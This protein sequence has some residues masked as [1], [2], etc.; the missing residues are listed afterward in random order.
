[1]AALRYNNVCWRSIIDS[2]AS[3]PMGVPVSWQRPR[4]RVRGVLLAWVAAS[5]MLVLSFA[6]PAHA[7]VIKSW[8]GIQP[9]GT[10]GTNIPIIISGGASTDGF[11]TDASTVKLFIDGALYPRNRYYASSRS[12]AGLYLLCAPSPALTDGTHTF[13]V[14]IS[15]TAGKLS[16]YQWSARVAQAPAASWVS[17]AAG[18]IY[19]GGRP[20]ITM[21]LSDNTPG[22]HLAVAGQVRTGSATGAVVSTFSG[23]GL[24]G[25]V[26]SFALPGEIAPGTYYLTAT[27]TDGSG[28]IRALTGRL[29]RS[30]KTVLLPAMTRSPQSCLVAGCHVTTGHPATGRTCLQCH[31]PGYHEDYECNEC[32]APHTGPVTVKGIF[33]PCTVCHN[34]SYPGVPSHTAASVTPAHASSC[35]GCHTE[36]LLDR[37][38]VTPE[39][40]AYPYQCDLCH[41]STD[42]DV[43][44]AIAAGDASCSAC[45]DREESH[46][47]LTAIHQSTV[48]SGPVRVLTSPTTNHSAPKDG[49]YAC[50][51][52]HVST[53]LLQAHGT[54]W[55]DCSICH[56]SGGPRSTFDSWNK[57][58]QQGDCHVT[59]HDNGVTQANHASVMTSGGLCGYCHSGEGENYF[60]EAQDCAVVCHQARVPVV[61]DAVAP[62]T[63]VSN[64]AAYFADPAQVQLS[65]TDA[66]SGVTGIYY[67]ADGGGWVY[68]AGSTTTVSVLA[69]GSGLLEFKSVDWLGNTEEIKSYTVTFD[70]TP[71]VTTVSESY[72]GI[73]YRL[74]FSD[75]GSGVA[76]TYFSVDGESFRP[77]GYF[78][79]IDGIRTDGG[80]G[81][82]TVRYYSVDV[83]GNTEDP[84]TVT[85]VIPDNTAPTSTLGRTDGDSAYIESVDAYAD[86]PC[87]IKE[88]RYRLDGGDWVVATF[89]RERPYFATP[90]RADLVVPA[91]GS[92]QLEYFAVDWVDNA[93]TPQTTTLI[94]DGVAPVLAVTVADSYTGNA[95]IPASATDVGSGVASISYRLDSYPVVNRAGSS[96]SIV[97]SAPATGYRTYT[98]SV[99]ATDN[100]GNTSEIFGPKTI[101]V[102]APPDVTAPVTNLRWKS[103]LASYLNVINGQSFNSGTLFNLLSNDPSGI[104]R[105]EYRIDGGELQTVAGSAAT[106]LWVDL[107]MGAGVHTISFNAVDRAGNVEN[108]KTIGFT[109]LPEFM[110][111]LFEMSNTAIPEVTWESSNYTYDVWV[112]RGTTVVNETTNLQTVDAW[113][114]TPIQYKGFSFW[115]LG[116]GPYTVEMVLHTHSNGDQTYT[117]SDV[118]L[119][120]GETRTL[121][122]TYEDITP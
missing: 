116:D 119:A 29:A 79:N 87:G 111:L 120:D 110:A 99:W 14:E 16:A 52:C 46:G 105:I 53:N 68:T 7:G 75:V 6:S 4:P 17:P 115:D 63:T 93:E 21:S 104:A 40:S 121:T 9:T 1:M 65:A 74:T 86:N 92:Y 78:E 91:D 57:S 97:L 3:T 34:E 49:I 42:P 51:M 55:N 20:P 30:F 102:N 67:R 43:V 109:V 19:Y 22:A 18:S 66:G 72:N 58:C 5:A 88:I 69:S 15:D 112:R 70:V 107:S 113:S 31:V 47:D 8:Y 81:V 10:V 2:Y 13:R 117:W 96:T 23:T 54:S 103:G 28:Y 89:P 94:I 25:G 108:T 118:A 82:H 90:R 60:Y 80:G 41:A 64:E 83:A 71:P 50:G 32:H 114:G 56:S 27:V 100:A 95:V 39:G 59:L 37:H 44:A 101:V 77:Y 26:T 48:T 85:W 84:V 11:L 33:G 35:E 12:G 106:Y 73:P 122:G 98:L 61:G 62:V 36:S 38:A 76:T 24:A 45:H